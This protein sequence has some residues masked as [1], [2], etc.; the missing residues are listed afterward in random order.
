MK[1]LRR[2]L[3]QAV[4]AGWVDQGSASSLLGRLTN[5]DSTLAGMKLI[6]PA[7]QKQVD[8]VAGDFFRLQ[9]GAPGHVDSGK[10]TRSLGASLDEVISKKLITD[11]TAGALRE[12]LNTLGKGADAS[13]AWWV[14]T[15]KALRLA[16]AQAAQS[17][18]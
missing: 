14:D 3:D 11:K 8:Q 17:R 18:T 4:A 2:D 10:V 7:M 15:A 12:K 6:D 9:F 13:S 5:I 16:I 1:I